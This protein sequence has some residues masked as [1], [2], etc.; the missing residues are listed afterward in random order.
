M[1]IQKWHE[2]YRNDAE[3]NFFVGK[4]GKSGLVR[5]SE[6]HWR[7]TDS[8]AKEG[9]LSKEQTEQIIDRYHKAGI[10]LQSPRDP[11]KWAYWENVSKKKDPYLTITEEDQ[12]MRLQRADPNAP[13]LAKFY[14]K[15]SLKFP[16]SPV[17]STPKMP[18]GSPVV[19]PSMPPAPSTP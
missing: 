3:K 5:H 13:K 15:A 1:K 2:V 6:F 10:I 4:D 8:L 12:K 7:S 19:A 18:T 17:I 11:E 9:G 16:G 14:K